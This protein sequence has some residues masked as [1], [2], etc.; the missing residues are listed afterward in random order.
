MHRLF[1]IGS[2]F[3]DLYK[4]IKKSSCIELIERKSKFIGHIKPVVSEYDAIDF[5]SYIK[6]NSRNANH[7]VYAYSIK[8]EYV[9][10]CSDDGE[11]V[12]TAGMP[13]LGI[14]KKHEIIDAV[15]VITRYF[16]GILLGSSGLIKTYSRVAKLVI[17]KSTIISKHL[18]LKTIV[19]L[20][21]NLYGKMCKEILSED[22]K[23]ENIYFKEDIKIYFCVK[24]EKYKKFE[25]LI[26]NIGCGKLKIQILG[27][28][29]MEF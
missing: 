25:L 28:Y 17:D 3:L 20:D 13:V 10:R 7:N 22:I 29:Y 16:G 6:T 9:F 24:K 21:Y 8:K 23:I 1:C 14:L 12:G 11:P 15:I 18:C 26:K 5:I 27:E 2:G 19:N 4:T